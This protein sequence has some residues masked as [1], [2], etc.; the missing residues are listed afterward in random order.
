MNYNVQIKCKLLLLISNQK[1]VYTL[2]QN[3]KIRKKI[4]TFFYPQLLPNYGMLLN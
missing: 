1:I 2:E 3:D 4:V